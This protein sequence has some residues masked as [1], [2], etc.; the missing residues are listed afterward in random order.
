MY[1]IEQRMICK[2]KSYPCARDE[3]ILLHYHFFLGHK[4]KLNIVITWYKYAVVVVICY[5]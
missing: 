1:L 5:I 4:G 2:Q 3:K